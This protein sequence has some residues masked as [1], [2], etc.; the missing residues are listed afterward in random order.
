MLYNS[1]YT[2]QCYTTVIQ[3]SHHTVFAKIWN[4]FCKSK[5]LNCNHSV[6]MPN[7]HRHRYHVREYQIGCLLKASHCQFSDN[8]KQ[9]YQNR[10]KILLRGPAADWP[11]DPSESTFKRQPASM[12]V[13]T[14]RV[15]VSY[16]ATQKSPTIQT[17]N[18]VV[19]LVGF[20]LPAFREQWAHCS[21]TFCTLAVCKACIVSTSCQVDIVDRTFW[22]AGL[23]DAPK[24]K[25]TR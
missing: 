16:I 18:L 1:Y 14:I 25:R 24:W 8:I 13:R 21:E 15:L 5:Q 17:F 4:Q 22:R 9:Q 23:S 19:W 12:R 6:R 2:V 7:R 20:Q 11:M 3:Y 10:L